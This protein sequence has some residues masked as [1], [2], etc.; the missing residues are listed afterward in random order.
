MSEDG[1]ARRATKLLLIGTAFVLIV[2]DV[3]VAYFNDE[4]GDTIS[5]VVHD[6]G[7]QSWFVLVGI[8]VLLGHWF[9]P[10][11]DRIDKD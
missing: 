11:R 9:W 5:A 6:A 3:F 8:G 7:A 4:R 1:K 2:F 10:L